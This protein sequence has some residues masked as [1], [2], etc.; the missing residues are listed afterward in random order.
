MW[1]GS[2]EETEDRISVV[3][4]RVSEDLEEGYPGRLNVC[5]VYSLTKDNS[6]EMTFIASGNAVPTVVNM[7]NHAYWNLSGNVKRTVD[8]HVLQIDSDAYLDGEDMI[9]RDCPVS[10]E[11]SCMDFREP[12]TLTPAIERMDSDGRVGIDHAFILR[13]GFSTPKQLRHVASLQ[14]NESGRRIDVS[15]T[16]CALIVYTANWV[17]EYPHCAVCLEPGYYPD[18]PNHPSFPT[19]VLEPGQEYVHRTVFHFSVV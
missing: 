18:T 4:K 11:G 7:T 3:F 6:L 1:T 9:P 8:Q 14:D 2:I 5:A 12:H 16:E 10:V 17:E 15:T 19:S 13:S